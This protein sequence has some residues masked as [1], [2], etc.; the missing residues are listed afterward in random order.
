MNFEGSRSPL[1][2]YN[3]RFGQ[4]MMAINSGIDWS[5]R[6]LLANLNRLTDFNYVY[7]Q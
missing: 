4:R 7:E 3:D 6:R 2:D 5:E 1:P